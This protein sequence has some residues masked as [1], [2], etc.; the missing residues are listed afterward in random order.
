[1]KRTLSLLDVGK[2]S[3]AGVFVAGAP[4]GVLIVEG[5]VVG[6]C[7]GGGLLGEDAEEVGLVSLGGGGVAEVG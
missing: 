1:M 6:G 4:G 2:R 7:V 5:A 3:R